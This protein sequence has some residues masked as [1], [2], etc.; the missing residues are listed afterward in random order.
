M[1]KK[2]LTIEEAAE[3]LGM[4]PSELNRLR[5]KGEIR[6]FADRGTWKL[7]EEDVDR[8]ARSRQADSDPEVP[9]MPD[10]SSEGFVLGEE[11]VSEDPTVI[12][13]RHDSDSDVK[14][15]FD[16]SLEVKPTAG[17]PLSDS[18]S[19]VRL[20]SAPA[21]SGF[22]ET[23]SDVVLPKLGS[24]SDSDVKLVSPSSVSKKKGSD[25]DVK[26]V[27]DSSVSK[28]K[29]HSD[30]DVT[31]LPPDAPTLDLGGARGQSGSVLDDNDS[32]IS[33]AGDS[34]ISLAGDSGISLEKSVDSGITLDDDAA[35]RL[36]G[37][38]GISLES[39]SSI[40]RKSPPKGKKPDLGGTMPMMDRP[41]SGDD[42]N[43]TVTELPSLGDDSE[44]EFEMAAAGTE[45]LSLGDE[46]SDEYS[47]AIPADEDGDAPMAAVASR[48]TPSMED[49][50]A[51]VEID[52][53]T[54]SGA[55]DIVDDDD[56]LSEDVDVFGADDDDF[57]SELES[58]E[59]SA[60]MS[61][62]RMAAP[63]EQDWGLGVGIGLCVSTVLMVCTGISMYDLMRNLWQAES[64]LN[65][66][67]S[68]LLD[69]LGGMF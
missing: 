31:L 57:E 61:V 17:K 48:K 18:D 5:E 34:G 16:D 25:S 9:L 46:G 10:E 68:M 36:A 45:T 33:L 14:L 24:D 4:Q 47:V 35:L 49:S 29:A 62:G 1:Q 27:S 30:S 12:R 66:L 32:G 63:V 21:V 42:P 52:P 3:R 37:D 55:M 7:K 51:E 41:M 65:P 2:Y 67:S 56:A 64:D 53:D 11:G 22:S 40:A 19:D 23:I 43:R 39:P 26:L 38:S 13:P 8:L 59:S 20:H 58:G 69:T 50:A 44:S 15:V 60:E 54:D 28:S 6:A